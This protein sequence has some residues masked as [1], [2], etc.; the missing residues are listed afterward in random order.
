MDDQIPADKVREVRDLHRDAAKMATITDAEREIHQHVADAME[1]LLLTPPTLPTLADMTYDERDACQWMQ[2]EVKGRK[3]RV[4][5]VNPCWKDGGA[6]VMWLHTRM[7]VV[8][9]GNITPRPDLPRMEW[10]GDQNPAPA[11]ALPGGWR[12]ADHKDHGRVIVTNTTPNPGGHVYYVL[13]VGR[14]LI[15]FDWRSC[16]PA[17]LTYIDQE[18][19]Q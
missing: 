4:V 16:D 3:T 12:L 6:R 18:D 5:I 14:N 15:G 13:P 8:P 17:E 9:W 10:P 7:G 11:P 1:A 2:A 19:D